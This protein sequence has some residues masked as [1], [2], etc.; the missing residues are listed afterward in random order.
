MRRNRID[1][2]LN[3]C[4]LLKGLYF[5]SLLIL[6]VIISGQRTFI[7][8][9]ILHKKSDL[10]RMKYMV[11]AKVDPWYASYLLM[12]ADER[13]SYDYVVQKDPSW[14]S[15]SREHPCYHCQGV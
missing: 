7:H 15:L 5:V 4:S 8:P 12:K 2:K 6:P 13:S 9:G 10:D 1:L 11:Q 3:S 14:T